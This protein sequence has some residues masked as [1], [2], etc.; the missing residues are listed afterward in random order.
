[1][2]RVGY[3]EWCAK[4]GGYRE[5]C[6]KGGGIGNGVLRVGVQGMVC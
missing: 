5:W 6:A 2:L 4:G 1:M 3:R